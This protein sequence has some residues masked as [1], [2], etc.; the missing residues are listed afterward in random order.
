MKT[1][2]SSK[3]NNPNV[4]QVV[5]AFQQPHARQLKHRQYHRRRLQAVLKGQNVTQGSASYTVAKTLLKGDD[6]AAH[7]FSEKAWQAQKRYMWRTLHFDRGITVKE[8]VA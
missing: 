6:A 8:W 3:Q 5:I 7:I 4:K 2:P 1:A